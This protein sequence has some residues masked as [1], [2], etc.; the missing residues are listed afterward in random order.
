[1]IPGHV[2]D[3]QHFRSAKV[4]SIVFPMGYRV[5]DSTDSIF[6]L[7]RPQRKMWYV[8]TYNVV[9]TSIGVYRENAVRAVHAVRPPRRRGS[10]P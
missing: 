7:E 4:L 5:L 3:G 1:M 10:Q 8:D 9:C 6:P 2:M